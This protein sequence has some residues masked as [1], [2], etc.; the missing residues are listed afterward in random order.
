MGLTIIP[1][2]GNLPVEELN[3]L[4]V[5][6]TRKKLLSEDECYENMFNALLRHKTDILDKIQVKDDG[7]LGAIAF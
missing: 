4:S 2:G 3:M 7:S 5:F 6:R 1:D